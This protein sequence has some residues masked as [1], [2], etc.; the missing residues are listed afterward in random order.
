MGSLTRHD[1]PRRIFEDGVRWVEAIKQH[2]ADTE[3]F[4][5]WAMSSPA[6]MDA[7]TQAWTIWHEVSTLSCE[8]RLY[9]EWLATR[10]RIA[11]KDPQQ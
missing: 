4:A 5:R 2:Q 3:A 9:I 10:P 11:K 7:F 6:H 8:Q 1:M